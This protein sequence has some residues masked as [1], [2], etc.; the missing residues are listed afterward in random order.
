ME[1]MTWLF[2]I[3]LPYDGNKLCQL[4]TTDERSMVSMEKTAA[5]PTSM[6][7]TSQTNQ[8]PSTYNNKR[9]SFSRTADVDDEKQQGFM[10]KVQIRALGSF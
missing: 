2:L 9:N 1:V 10:V 8:I 6:F 7:L 5:A 3:S 4:L